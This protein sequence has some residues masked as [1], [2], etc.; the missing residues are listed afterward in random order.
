M[1]DLQMPL[2]WKDGR[3]GFQV[4]SNADGDLF[5]II[6]HEK[7]G[8]FWHQVGL[9]KQGDG[10]YKAILS[11]ERTSIKVLPESYNLILVSRSVPIDSNLKFS[12]TKLSALGIT[13]AS[14]MSVNSEIGPSLQS[15]FKASSDANTFNL[16]VVS[17][18]R[19]VAKQKSLFNAKMASLKSQG[20]KN[21]YDDAAKTVNPP[22]QSEHHTGY[23][24]DIFIYSSDCPWFFQRLR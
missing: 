18:F 15:M 16:R 5:Q 23:A 17:G 6:V 14:D 13:R 9:K 8:L 19:T 4:G 20:S 10:S 12:L 7:N 3:F 2:I 22:T 24:V 11:K 21:P 1:T